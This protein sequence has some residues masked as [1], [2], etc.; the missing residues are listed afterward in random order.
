MKA[1]CI[2]ESLNIDPVKLEDVVEY[3][4][5]NDGDIRV[6]SLHTRF[7]RKPFYHFFRPEGIENMT[8]REFD[9]ELRLACYADT[10]CDKYSEHTVKVMVDCTIMYG[11][12]TVI[13]SIDE[14]TNYIRVSFDHGPW[15][16]FTNYGEAFMAICGHEWKEA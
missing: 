8:R 7:L 12:K 3:E 9:S 2:R 16:L 6:P 11:D 15:E 10:A 13:C 4:L 14:R 5:T 1:T